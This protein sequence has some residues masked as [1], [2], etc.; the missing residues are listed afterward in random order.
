MCGAPRDFQNSSKVLDKAVWDWFSDQIS[1]PEH[2]QAIY[3]QYVQNANQSNDQEKSRIRAVRQLIDDARREE[4]SYLAALGSAREDYRDILVGRAQEANDRAVEAMKE[5]EELEA[6]VVGRD[7]QL[8]L[9]ESFSVV[10]LRAA[11]KLKALGRRQAHGPAHLR[12]QSPSLGK[13]PLATIPPDMVWAGST[14]AF[15][16]H[17]RYSGFR[18]RLQALVVPLWP[19][20][21]P[22]GDSRFSD[23]ANATAPRRLCPSRS[24]FLAAL[25]SR[26]RARSALR[27]GMPADGQALW[28]HHATARTRLA[29]DR[30]D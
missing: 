17:H 14:L 21:L 24:M 10:S 2:M 16:S 1:D 11:D 25:W 3:E 22:K 5:L 19:L 18:G 27:A 12:G 29:R 23:A 6:M 20:T 15:R 4:E 26:C 28:D 8:S 13:R 7:Q 9:L 30:Q